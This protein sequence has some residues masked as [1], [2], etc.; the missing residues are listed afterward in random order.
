VTHAVITALAP[1]FGGKRT[2]APAIVKALG[3]HNAF[4]DVFCGSMAVM[5]AKPP[6]RTEVVNDLHADLVNLA[7]VIQDPILGPALYRRLRRVW[8]SQDL[9]ADSLDVMRNSDVDDMSSPD[10]ARAFHYF[11]ASWQG[12]NGVAGTSQYKTNY[13]RRF[14][15]LGGDAGARWVGAV[16]SIPA[17]RTRMERVQV[18]R[19]DGI[20]L[21]EKIEDRGGVA[22]YADPPYLEKGAKYLH[23]FKAEDHGRLAEVLCRFKRTRVVVSYYADPRVQDLYPGWHL[24]HVAAAKGLVQSGKRDTKG[25]TDAPEVLISNLPFP[26]DTPSLFGAS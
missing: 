15:S 14:S 11:V 22:V 2:M 7:R 20:D 4:W 24:R 26:D 13:A 23:D 6:C 16:R 25:R 19:C 1:W 21:C 10:V 3:H 5:L 12:M 18:L 9:F 8:S 17:W